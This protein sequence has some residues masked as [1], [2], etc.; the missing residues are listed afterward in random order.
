MFFD[1]ELELLA[2]LNPLFQKRK[3][4][5]QLTLVTLRYVR[6]CMYTQIS[7]M[8]VKCSVEWEQYLTQDIVDNMVHTYT[9]STSH[10]YIVDSVV[11][12]YAVPHII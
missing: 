10:T 12:T 4:K 8:E 6:M 1:R 5:T 9:H 3:I 2:S 7:P 11:R